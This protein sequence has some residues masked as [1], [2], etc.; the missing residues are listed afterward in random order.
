MVC[1]VAT[2]DVDSDRS[3]EGETL[4]DSRLNEVPIVIV[5]LRLLQHV[6]C[7]ACNHICTTCCVVVCS[8]KFSCD[9]ANVDVVWFTIICF[10]SNSCLL[11]CLKML[12]THIFGKSLLL[13]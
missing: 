7:T 13:L 10:L 4:H 6:L 9:M 1:S 3:T 2:G 8:I 5:F 12:I 11:G